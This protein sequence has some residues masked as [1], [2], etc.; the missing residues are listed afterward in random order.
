MMPLR[1]NARATLLLVA[2]TLVA[3]LPCVEAVCDPRYYSLNGCSGHGYCRADQGF[4]TMGTC[5]CFTGWTGFDC[6][7]RIRTTTADPYGDIGSDIA[8]GIFQRLAVLGCLSL[9]VCFCGC[10]FS[11]F[12]NR[13][14]NVYDAPRHPAQRGPSNPY[15]QNTQRQPAA[16]PLTAAVEMPAT[17]RTMQVT[18]PQ[19]VWPGQLVQ[20]ASPWGQQVQV[21][22][23]AGTQPGAVFTCS[24]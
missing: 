1:C 18:C 24:Y 15:W 17:A 6:S 11:A 9:V 14:N 21:T 13:N 10:L 20:V 5:R 3:P 2:T 23:P 22:V 7:R 16:Q 19:G 8:L 4:N 12:C